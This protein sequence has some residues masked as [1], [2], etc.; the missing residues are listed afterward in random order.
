MDL[1]RSISLSK[2]LSYIL[3]HKALELGLIVQKGGWV[4]L[5]DVLEILNHNAKS[6][7]LKEEVEQVVRTSDKQRFS[8]ENNL[9][10]A[11][12]GHSFAV[13]LELS[14]QT[15]PA[16]LYHGTH[17]NILPII[18]QEGLKKI[19]RHHVHLSPTIDVA[20]KVG[21]RRGVPVVLEVNAQ[22]MAKDGL[23]F[24]CSSNGVWLV[25]SVPPQYLRVL[26]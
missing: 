18:L 23:I 16:T 4:N 17:R 14:P 11:N 15:P 6:I 20:I 8:L 5:E 10:R 22:Q 26:S 25:G 9:I 3:R 12:Q 13:D 7:I 21:Q 2:R 1:K 19:G 24:F